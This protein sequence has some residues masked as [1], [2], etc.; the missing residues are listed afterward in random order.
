MIVR[1]GLLPLLFL[2]VT[3]T[4]EKPNIVLVVA[5]D[6]G[7]GDLA[8]FGATDV[9]TP[10]LDR[11]AAEGLKLTAC[12]AAHANCSPSRTALMTGRTPTRVGVR[13]WIPE[14]SPVHV[15]RS[16]ITVATLL[17]NGGYTT[18]LS[19]KWHL[20][21]QFNQPSQPQPNDH[22]FDHWFATQN[23][24]YPNHR[25]PDNF[26]RNG[27][28]LGR[29]EGYAAHLVADEATRWLTQQRDKTK[30]FFL[31][32][33]FH[34]PHEPIASDER[35]TRLY[36]HADPAYSAHH[37]NITQMDDAFGKL[38]AALDAEGLRENTL[39]VFT[40]DNGPA[41]TPQHPYG[42][43]GPLRSKKGS[44]YEGGIRVPGL[45]RWPG[46]I[47]PGSVSGEPVCGVDFLPT[48]CALTGLPA[49]RD[50]A[51]DGTSVLPLFEGGQVERATPLYWHFNRATDE[52]KVALRQGDWK[53]LATL[54]R[55]PPARENH[56]TAALQ[57]DFK[58]A[59]LV[60][61]ELYHLG[62]D[63]GETRDLAAS[64]PAK[65]AELKALMEAKYREVRAESPLWPD[66]QSPGIEG[67]RIA[68]PDYV[69]QRQGKG[70]A[71]AKAK[72]DAK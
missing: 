22:G 25:H 2:A 48:V 53:L 49:P 65:L 26:V 62:N 20:N 9:Q 5:D 56:L 28:A 67:R 35:Y 6:L 10:N 69:L 15:P 38:M 70:K 43:A 36:P 57:Q 34:E 23:N 58:A 8:C 52:P 4:A 13:D 72:A 12:Y 1:L 33:A 61:F 29:L 66:W 7:Y 71:K 50:R 68:W 64:E 32:V 63:L 3:A 41:I 51:L 39:V 16:E 54:D 44:L 47:A 42:S 18:C 24:A 30:P 60:R 19:G 40:S 45:V 27:Q 55:V 46:R 17:R 31:Y 21:G 11:L 14:E 59:E 37:G